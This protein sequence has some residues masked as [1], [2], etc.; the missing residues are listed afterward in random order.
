MI[1]RTRQRDAIQTAFEE[2]GRPL[3]PSEVHAIVL[4]AIPGVG[5]STIYRT[6][7]AFVESGELVAVEMP[8]QPDRYETALRAAQHHH[9]FHCVTCDRMFDVPGCA[10][11]IKQL[12]PEGFTLADHHLTLSG[13]CADCND[14]S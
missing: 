3:S 12:T 6:V 2:A 10:P 7:R 14:E 9:H 4:D 8:G 1:R 13:T 5:L 11:A